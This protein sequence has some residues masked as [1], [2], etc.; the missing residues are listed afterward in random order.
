MF[1][2]EVRPKSPSPIGLPQA[3]P[4]LVH[5]RKHEPAPDE[6]RQPGLTARLGE[7]TRLVDLES[8][9]RCPQTEHE[10]PCV[11]TG[12]EQPQRSLALGQLEP[13]LCSLQAWSNAL[14][15]SSRSRSIAS[16][17]PRADWPRRGLQKGLL[18]RSLPGAARR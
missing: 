12:F 7:R 15:A 16:Q 11:V 10:F 2:R 18:R 4:I 5:Q 1:F 13:P 3:C 17:R 14:F 8:N 9:K 6:D